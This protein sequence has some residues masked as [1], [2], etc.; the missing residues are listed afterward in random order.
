MKRASAPEAGVGTGRAF[1]AASFQ[2]GRPWRTV[3][4]QGFNPAAKQRARRA[5]SAPAVAGAYRCAA[6]PA[7]SF[8]L[9]AGEIRNQ[10][11]QNLLE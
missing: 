6:S 1:A 7:A 4:G 3:E 8:F 10:T 5:Q 2:G 9:S 11:S